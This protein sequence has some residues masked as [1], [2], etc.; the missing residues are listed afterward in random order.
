MK[1]TIEGG[2]VGTNLRAVQRRLGCRDREEVREKQ[3]LLPYPTAT[4]VMHFLIANL[5]RWRTPNTV[6][7]TLTLYL[8]TRSGAVNGGDTHEKASTFCNLSFIRD[9]GTCNAIVGQRR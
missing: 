2:R 8:K 1:K 4:I 6:F 9:L 3:Q 5:P 7:G